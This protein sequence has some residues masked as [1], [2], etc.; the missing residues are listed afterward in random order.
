MKRVT[1]HEEADTETIEAARYYE[2]TT[3]PVFTRITTRINS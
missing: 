1:F 2:T 3:H